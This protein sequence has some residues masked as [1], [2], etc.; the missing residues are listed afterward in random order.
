MRGRRA[1]F[2]SLCFG[3]LVSAAV[4]SLHR[5][6]PR[7]AESSV[8]HSAPLGPVGLYLHPRESNTFNQEFSSAANLFPRKKTCLAAGFS[9]RE[10]P[11][12][13][14][15]RYCNLRQV[16]QIFCQHSDIIPEAASL[17][18]QNCLRR[19]LPAPRP[20]RGPKPWVTLS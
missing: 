5:R 1:F 6:T 7:T 10:K 4:H 8:C 2:L 15:L 11:N 9:R 19:E 20:S 17:A 14:D 13:N 3:I 16:T 18:K 12:S